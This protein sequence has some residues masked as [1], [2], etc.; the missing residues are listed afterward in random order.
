MGLSPDPAKV[1]AIVDMPTPDSK[2]GVEHFLGCLQY[3]SHFLLQLS[4]VATPLRQLTEQSAIFT[5]Q[6]Q[7]DNAFK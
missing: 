3:L 7:Q 1:R 2:K 4:D 6:T 5:W